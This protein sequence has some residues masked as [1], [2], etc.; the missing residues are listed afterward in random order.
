MLSAP[1]IQLS[2]C[3]ATRP[4]TLH[5]PLTHLSLTA[6]LHPSLPHKQLRDC[7]RFTLP[8]APRNPLPLANSYETAEADFK[9]LWPK[10]VLMALSYAPVS[11]SPQVHY[12]AGRHVQGRV[13]GGEDERAVLPFT[14]PSTTPV[15]SSCATCFTP[16][17]SAI[18]EI[19]SFRVQ[20]SGLWP[21]K[22]SVKSLC[23]ASGPVK[24]LALISICPRLPAPMH[25]SQRFLHSTSPDTYNKAKADGAPD[26][27]ARLRCGEVKMGA[28]GS[29]PLKVRRWLCSC[30]LCWSAAAAGAGLLVLLLS[31]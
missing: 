18:S 22:A 31:Y 13:E 29:S 12:S 11:S 23:K 14:S 8:T 15:T 16:D 30:L 17:S 4:L 28:D 10:V 1:L 25:A 20:G 3:S 7:C 24:S 9:A 6:P 2:S 19:G 5:S 26:R 27:L 21:C